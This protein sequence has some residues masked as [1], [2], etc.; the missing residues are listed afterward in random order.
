M[1]SENMKKSDPTGS[2]V[3]I[4][5]PETRPSGNFPFD[6][7]WATV[8]TSAFDNVALQG[9]SYQDRQNVIAAVVNL[10][11]GPGRVFLADKLH[12]IG[13][14]INLNG[15]IELNGMSAGAA[16]GTIPT[17]SN[18]NGHLYIAT[19]VVEKPM[20]EL[21]GS[22]MQKTT[23]V[24]D[25]EAIKPLIEES[26]TQLYEEQL[27]L[28]NL[29][30]SMPTETDMARQ[31]NIVDNLANELT[32]FITDRD[33]L[34][35]EIN[36]INNEVASMNVLEN[37]A[38]QLSMVVNN[39]GLLLNN[40]LNQ[41]RN[42][43]QEFRPTAHDEAMSIQ[44]EYRNATNRLQAVQIT[45]SRLRAISNGGAVSGMEELLQK[46]KLEVDTAN[47]NLSNASRLLQQMT[48]AYESSASQIEQSRQKIA[49]LTVQV[50]NLQAAY[51]QASSFSDS[52]LSLSD[53]DLIKVFADHTDRC[54]IELE[55]LYFGALRSYSEELTANSTTMIEARN[56][57]EVVDYTEYMEALQDVSDAFTSDEITL[58][59]M[60]GEFGYS[61][62][63]IP[64]A[65]R[66]YALTGMGP[67]DRR[68]AFR[69]MIEEILTLGESRSK[70][71]FFD[72]DSPLF[73]LE[74]AL[75]RD[76]KDLREL[77]QLIEFLTDRRPD[78]QYD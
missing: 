38:A 40:K 17:N 60:I 35:N 21:W 13:E 36:N 25:A 18:D 65:G 50:Q 33:N 27:N 73:K 59:N 34:Q 49:E 62:N 1:G 24:H 48:T 47:G 54:L 15:R 64:G 31:T 61:R 37:E 67:T 29:I 16:L 55:A 68:R 46:R 20:Q 4:E 57:D 72:E 14:I 75:K 63:Y 78:I 66:I 41:L 26:L 70:S 5:Y 51:E 22:V 53:N 58:L 7:F 45:L 77:A 11:N 42:V 6:G 32:R 56:S 9:A 23:S 74:L 43:S 71:G 2:G 76:N 52:V 69:T 39:T 44:A 19:K 3:T 10:I 12:I 28:Q 30:A 8:G